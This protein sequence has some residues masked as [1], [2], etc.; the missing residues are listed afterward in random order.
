MRCP[1]CANDN[2]D[3]FRFCLECGAQLGEAPSQAAGAAWAPPAERY[4]PPNETYAM[5]DEPRAGR[6]PAPPVQRPPTAV[7]AQEP[8]ALPRL[9]V[10]HGATGQSE[11]QLTAPP[12]AIGRSRSNDIIVEDVKVSR[13]HAR[14][15]RDARGFAIEDL[16]SRNGTRVNNQSVRGSS[17][18]EDGTVIQIGD[19]GFRFDH[20]PEPAIVQP[21]PAPPPLEQPAP[22]HPPQVE[23][24]KGDSIQVLFSVAWAP[25]HCPNCRGIGTMR[26]IVYGPAAMTAAAQKAAQ[27]G[28]VVLGGM[29]VVSDSPNAQ[30]VT[31][32]TRVRIIPA[33]PE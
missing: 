11:Y 12:I 25:I 20:A 1:H 19:A 3:E 22:P 26:P 6:T 9:V 27:R 29:T 7:P 33:A 30:C 4:A 24:R 17:R 10:L 8:A 31:C 28:E 32:G 2:P 5:V 23:H 14:I 13:Q 21:A 18:L 16:N 15:V